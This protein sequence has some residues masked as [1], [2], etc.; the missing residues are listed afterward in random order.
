[1][2]D[3]LKLL[4]VGAGLLLVGACAGTTSNCPILI[5]Y[6]SAQQNAAADELA[7]LGDVTGKG[8]DTML[9]QMI[10]DYGLMRAQCR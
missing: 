2:K 7:L 8:F 3:K 6:N 9:D 1:M 4:L 10:A 5:E